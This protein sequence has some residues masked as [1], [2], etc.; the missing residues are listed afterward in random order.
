[1]RTELA[2]RVEALAGNDP[3]VVYHSAVAAYL[4]PSDRERFDLTMRGLVAAGA[5]RWVSNEAPGVLPSVTATAATEPPDAAFVLGVDG[6]AVAF[7]DGH[8]AWAR[9]LGA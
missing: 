6:R 8:G 9:W 3:V 1:M 5:C 7:T 2:R 4:A